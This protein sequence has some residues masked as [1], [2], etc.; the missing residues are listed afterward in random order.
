MWG[1]MHEAQAIK[2][3]MQKTGNK[4]KPAGLFIFPCGLLGSSPDGIIEHAAAQNDHGVL[5]IKCPWKF[6]NN[7]IEEILQIELGNKEEKVAN[8]AQ[9]SATSTS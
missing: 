9:F 5:E 8:K 6:R 3:Y 1:K 4:V 2:D 7:T